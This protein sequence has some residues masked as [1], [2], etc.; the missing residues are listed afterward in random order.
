MVG[1]Q[2]EDTY[3]WSYVT[4]TK[5]FREYIV[6]DLVEWMNIYNRGVK[7]HIVSLYNGSTSILHEQLFLLTVKNALMTQ[8]SAQ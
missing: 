2:L 3:I 8:W 7:H 1:D 4:P 6:I 5:T